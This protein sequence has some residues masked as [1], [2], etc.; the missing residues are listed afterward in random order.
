MR[1]GRDAEIECA[2][3]D[4]DVV[5]VER[6]PLC[7]AWGSLVVADGFDGKLVGA[8][9][10]RHLKGDGEVCACDG[11]ETIGGEVVVVVDEVDREFAGAR[12]ALV[13][14]DADVFRSVGGGEHGTMIAGPSEGFAKRCGVVRVLMVGEAGFGFDQGDLAREAL[15]EGC[16]DVFVARQEQGLGSGEGA[17]L[18]GDEEFAPL[19]QVGFEYREVVCGDHEDRRKNDEFEAGEILNPSSAVWFVC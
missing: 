9:Q 7:V 19:L 11:G 8:F 15:G 2:F 5:S 10:V 14:I 13:G 18:C 4:G 16:D 12:L 1:E 3:A 17:G 6:L